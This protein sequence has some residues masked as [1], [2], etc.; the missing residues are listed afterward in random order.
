MEALD[1]VDV[2]Q[3]ILSIKDWRHPFE[4][5]LGVWVD[6]LFDWFKDWHEWRITE[7]LTADRAISP[8]A[9]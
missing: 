9:T 5:E 3:E 8:R 4:I 6:L 1:G 2:K 7:I